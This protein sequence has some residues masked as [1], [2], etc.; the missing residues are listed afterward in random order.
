[1]IGFI[2]S[3]SAQFPISSRALTVPCNGCRIG[4]AAGELALERPA[5]AVEPALGKRCGEPCEHMGNV[6]GPGPLI[7][8]AA[9]RCMNSKGSITIWL[10]PSW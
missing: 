6:R 10:V 7:T 4:R 1:M 5:N 3:L 2:T 9:R 8:S